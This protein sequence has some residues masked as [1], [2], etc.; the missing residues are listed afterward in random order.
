METTILYTAIHGLYRVHIGVVVM[1]KKVEFAILCGVLWGLYRV[2][3]GV[4]LG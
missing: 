4:I 2:H 1:G 3:I